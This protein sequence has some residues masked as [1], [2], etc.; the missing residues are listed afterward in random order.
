M[1][2]RQQQQRQERMSMKVYL[3]PM[4]GDSESNMERAKI[5]L[6]K[7]LG[8][9]GTITDIRAERGHVAAEIKISTRWE[10]PPRERVKYLQKWLPT[11]VH[12]FKVNF[13]RGRL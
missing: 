7:A 2:P 11:R 8:F 9:R 12:D 6:A 13:G 1:K 3:A 4:Y 5:Q 10:L